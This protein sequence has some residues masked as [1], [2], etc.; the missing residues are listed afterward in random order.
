MEEI[1]K[2]KIS[3]RKYIRKE[4]FCKN[5]KCNKGKN[6]TRKISQNAMERKLFFRSFSHVLCL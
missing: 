1:Q 4:R 5:K 2:L 3:K 6:N